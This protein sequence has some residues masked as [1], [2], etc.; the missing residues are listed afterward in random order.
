MNSVM[1]LNERML[2]RFL[3]KYLVVIILFGILC[4]VGSAFIGY[5]IQGMKYTSSGSLVQNDNNYSLVASYEQFVQSKRFKQSINSKIDKS[6]WKNKNFKNDYEIVLTPN[7]S[8]SPFFSMDATSQNRKY[9]QYLENLALKVFITNVGKYLAGANVSIMENASKAKSAQSYLSLL[10]VGVV[11]LVAG[12]VLMSI[13]MVMNM[14][15]WG[16]VTDK[17]YIDDIYQLPLLGTMKVSDTK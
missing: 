7:G 6:K 13:L 4:G 11:G 12:I 15:W 9:S 3:K 16:K 10:K 5:K 2:V 8:N 1:E 17:E 14:L